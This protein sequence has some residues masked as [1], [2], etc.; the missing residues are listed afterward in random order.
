MTGSARPGG[1]GYAPRWEGSCAPK[2]RAQRTGLG[3]RPKSSSTRSC[4]CRPSIVSA[5]AP[6]GQLAAQWRRH[7]LERA[8]KARFECRQRHIADPRGARLQQ[9][10]RAQKVCRTNKAPV[11]LAALSSSS[12]TSG[13]A[14]Y[15]EAP[16]R[17]PAPSRRP[18][19][20]SRRERRSRTIRHGQAGATTLALPR[21][22]ASSS[23]RAKASSSGTSTRRWGS[24]PA[25]W[26]AMSRRS[27]GR[28]ERPVQ[29]QSQWAAARTRACGV[30][31]RSACYAAHFQVVGSSG[32]QARE[33]RAQ[34]K[35][36]AR[37]RRSHPRAMGEPRR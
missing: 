29:P 26:H 1:F 12:T 15:S 4:A 5:P 23:S 16:P 3:P 14:K 17:R 7:D 37:A 6:T 8:V 13:C 18:Q 36:S 35:E 2:P 21:A 20:A 24:W 27:A 31:I 28:S 10:R 19:P 33:G 25:R 9:P 30:E 32:P 22:G 11:E 34:P